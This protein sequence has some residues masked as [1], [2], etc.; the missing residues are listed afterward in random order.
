MTHWEKV[1]PGEIFDLQY[2]ELVMDQERVSR[3]L[4]D[5][6]G[7]EWDEKCVDFHKNERNVMSPS[8]LQVR[9]PMYEN[10]INR[11]K[12]YEKHLHPLIE[13]LQQAHV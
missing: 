4:I 7:L 2:E 12:P 13:L 11:W 3:Q 1:F 5:Y 6:V 10:S 8:N 9:Q